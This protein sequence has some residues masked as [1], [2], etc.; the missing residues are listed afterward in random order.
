[1]SLREIQPGEENLPA[2]KACGAMVKDGKCL[3]CGES[4]MQDRELRILLHA[5]ANVVTD[6]EGEV[7]DFDSAD[8]LTAAHSIGT[9]I[10][11]TVAL[12]LQQAEEREASCEGAITIGEG[13]MPC[14][15]CGRTDHTNHLDWLNHPELHEKGCQ[16]M[17]HK[18]ER[19]MQDRARDR[20]KLMSSKGYYLSG[21]DSNVTNII[22][23]YMCEFSDAENAELQ[24]QNQRLGSALAATG[25]RTK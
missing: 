25:K 9:H 13:E 19:N 12:A 8:F 1:M 6:R 5:F 3:S 15:A 2:C 10:A 23:G 20:L 4:E 22:V 14:N 18:K 11:S 21:C 24:K 7:S 17:G 16:C